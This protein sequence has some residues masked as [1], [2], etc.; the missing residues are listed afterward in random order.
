MCNPGRASAALLRVAQ[1]VNGDGL[2]YFFDGR[3]LY[4]KMVDPG[5]SETQASLL[6]LQRGAAC[7]SQRP[8]LTPHLPPQIPHDTRCLPRRGHLAHLRP[9]AC[10]VYPV[11]HPSRGQTCPAPCPCSHPSGST[12]WPQQNIDFCRDGVCVRGS[13]YWSLYYSISATSLSCPGY[14]CPLA[15]QARQC[16]QYTAQSAAV[17]RPLQP[18]QPSGALPCAASSSICSLTHS[19]LS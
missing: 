4:I 13:R 15:E 18:P 10:V 5:N 1:V 2:A 6:L 3:R 14:F 9:A 7:C 11:L 8:H 19:K 16:R 17:G 12:P